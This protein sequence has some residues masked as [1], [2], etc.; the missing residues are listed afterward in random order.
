MRMV[1]SNGSFV[2][3]GNNVKH[4]SVVATVQIEWSHSKL[5]RSSATRRA[6]KSAHAIERHFGTLVRV[7]KYRHAGAGSAVQSTATPALYHGTPALPHAAS[8]ELPNCD[9]V[10]RS[11]DSAEPGHVV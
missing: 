5:V 1:S 3:R 4:P 6:Q 8:V 9:Q 10:G 7:E 2:W 11:T